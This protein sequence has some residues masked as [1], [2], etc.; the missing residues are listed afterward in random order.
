MTNDIE[1]VRVPI[2]T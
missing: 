2:H 1:A